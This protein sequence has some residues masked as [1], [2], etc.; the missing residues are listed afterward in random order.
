M[1][2]K[3]EIAVVYIITKLELGGAQKVCLALFNQL[4]NNITTYLISGTQ[5]PLAKTVQH[6]PRAFLL[7]ELTREVSFSPRALVQE[8]RAF[9]ALV[10]VLQELKKKH[11]T[12]HVHTHS[13]KAGYMGRW[14]AFFAGIPTRIH[15]VHGFGFNDYQPKLIHTI[16]YILEYCTALITTAYICVSKHDLELGKQ[17]L[18]GFKQKAYLIRAAVDEQKF[19]AAQRLKVINNDV[20]IFGSIACFKPQKNT[21]DLLKAFY[22]VYKHNPHTRLEIIGDGLL[23]PTLEKWIAEHNLQKIITLHGWQEHVEQLMTRWDCFVLSSLWEGLPCSIVEALFMNIP[24]LAYNVGGIYEVLPEDNLVIPGQWQTLAEKMKQFLHT[25]SVP[26]FSQAPEF[27]MHAML[28]G[29]EIMYENL[30]QK[31]YEII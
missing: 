23:R 5:G 25:Q 8:V 22:E 24:V 14:A 15:T 29:H 18:P 13:T 6:N 19:I 28:T 7:P 16:A 9:F 26:E 31:S 4:S 3:K 21:L 2:E 20:V 27:T 12:V 11:A 30:K 1:N 17:K 10:K